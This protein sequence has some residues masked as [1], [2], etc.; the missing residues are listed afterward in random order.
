MFCNINMHYSSR[1]PV[2]LLLKVRPLASGANV[3]GNIGKSFMFIIDIFYPTLM[4]TRR[5]LRL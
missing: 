1:G 4:Q 5:N 2:V 3:R